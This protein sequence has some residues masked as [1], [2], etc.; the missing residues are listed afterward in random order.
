MELKKQSISGALWTFIDMFINKGAYFLTTIILAGIIGPEK[1]G[2]IGMVT[3]FVTI[4]NTL[5]DS[6][7]S[8]SLLR[9]K[10]VSDQDYSTVFVTNVLIKSELNLILETELFK[11]S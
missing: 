4:G 2:L 8:T 9:T 3:L 7:M 1:F 5:I 11:S 10:N 6:G